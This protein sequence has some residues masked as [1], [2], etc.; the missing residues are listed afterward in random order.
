MKQSSGV[1]IVE[2]VVAITLS[3]VVA[4]GLMP[5]LLHTFTGNTRASAEASLQHSADSALSVVSTNIARSQRFLTTPD[6]S[7]TTSPA[8]SG[9]TGSDSVLIIR[10]AATTAAPQNPSRQPVYTGAGGTN[11][12]TTVRTPV[13]INLVYYLHDR[14]LYQRTITPTLYGTCSNVGIF[15]KTSCLNCSD[16]PKDIALTKNVSDFSISYQPEDSESDDRYNSTDLVHIT[17]EMENN[18]YQHTSQLS[19]RLLLA[20]D[21]IGSD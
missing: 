10:Q 19:A 18:S 15:Q 9:W 5:L 13:F 1:T 7:N 8:P 17:L 6:H 20:G 14:T 2:V 4:I 12:C 11:N 16:K 21:S 3:T